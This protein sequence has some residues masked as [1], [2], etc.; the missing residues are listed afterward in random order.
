MDQLTNAVN[1]TIK[2]ITNREGKYLTFSLANEEYAIG[3]LEVKEIIGTMPI[4]SVPQTPLY[5]K[6]VL[7]LR[8]NVIP[9]ISLRLKFG[10]EELGYTEK[11]FIIVGEA[12]GGKDSVCVGVVVDSVS[13]V[14]N[15]KSGD[16]EETPNFGMHADIDY[17]LVMAKING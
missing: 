2:A 17:V 15:I 1:Q 5:V 11:I 7:N 10:M 6:G 14:V 9:I 3:I 12:K 13:E 4:T 16:I 8:G